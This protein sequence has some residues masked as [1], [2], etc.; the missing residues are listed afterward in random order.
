MIS[1]SDFLAYCRAIRALEDGVEQAVRAAFWDWYNTHPD[2]TVEEMRE[3]AIGLVRDLTET[4]SDAG[5]SLAAE[6]YDVE[7]E[8]EHV[9]LDTALI[10]T[11]VSDEDIKRLVHYQAGKLTE[12]DV[13]GFASN[14]GTYARDQIRRSANETIMLNCRRDR[15]KG[16]KF[17]RVPS[18]AET[19]AFCMMLAGR[20][21]VYLTAA[22]AGEQGHFHRGCDCKIVPGF[23]DDN[24]IEGYDPNECKRLGSEF[25]SIDDAY[26]KAQADGIKTAILVES[27]K[28]RGFEPGITS[29]G[30][31]ERLSAGEKSAWKEFRR[32]G[33]TEAAYRETET[34]YLSEVGRAFGCT[35]DAEYLAQPDGYEMWVAARVADKGEVLFKYATRAHKNPDAVINGILWEIKSP[36]NAYKTADL[37]VE[38]AAKF[39][40]YPDNPPRAIVSCTRL[41]RGTV[42]EVIEGAQG[43]VDDGTFEEILVVTD[44]VVITL[45][46]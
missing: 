11:S 30:L 7:A 37:L 13:S 27:D 32:K 21:F 22:T 18:G 17:A 24:P 39:E 29:S 1:R 9:K 25:E 20:G 5:A 14:L 3:F 6:W 42:E 36:R 28:R 2:S 45:K 33:K 15:R 4:Y 10:S 38:A 31:A 46:K 41:T 12:D 43:F 35:F 26:P 16:V 34:A 40:S 19:C 8:A 44:E 23:N